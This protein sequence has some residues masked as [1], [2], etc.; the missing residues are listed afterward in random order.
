M[1]PL[2]Q[3][4]A[5]PALRGGAQIAGLLLA[6]LLPII[7]LTPV[8]GGQT[9]PRR[10][11]MGIAI[12]F[13]GALLPSFMPLF[14]RTIVPMDYVVLLAKEG[15]VGLILALFIQIMFESVASVGALIDLARGATLANVFD[16]LTQDQQSIL[17]ALF[18]Q[19]A[20]V[21]FVSIGGMQLLFR[22]LAETFVLLPPLQLLPAGEFGPA[23]TAT[24]IALVSSL[25]LLAV[26]LGAPAVVVLFLTDFALGVINRVA[27]QIQVFFLG[28]TGK[29]SIGLIVVLLGLGMFTDLTISH[30]ATFVA[31]MRD[32]ARVMGS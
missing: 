22:T 14:A 1:D 3:L 26:Q 31:A 13:T 18:T 21:L 19:F 27:P 12:A 17:A 9:M 16:P 23:G 5:M 2:S 10:L 20:I 28:M 29:G 30:F 24:P 8:F 6:R 4:I 15:A 11:R 7:V 32:W 25:F